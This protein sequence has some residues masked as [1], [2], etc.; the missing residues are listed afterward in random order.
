MYRVEGAALQETRGRGG[1]ACLSWLSTRITLPASLDSTD[2]APTLSPY[3]P[4]F[5]A[6]DCTAIE[7]L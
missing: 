4:M 7:I 6:Y 3:S 2:R 5:F 1:H